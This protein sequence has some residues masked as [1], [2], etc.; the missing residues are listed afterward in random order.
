MNKTLFVVLIPVLL[1]FL[2]CQ[3]KQTQDNRAENQV[4]KIAVLIEYA[5]ST[6]KV[7]RQAFGIRVSRVGMHVVAVSRRKNVEFILK[8]KASEGSF[9]LYSDHAFA[10]RLD[11]VELFNPEGPAINIQAPGHGLIILSPGSE[12]MLKDGSLYAVPP[13]GEQMNACLYSEGNLIFYGSGKLLLKGNYKHALYSRGYLKLAENCD[14]KVS[15]AKKD[16][17]HILGD[18][19]IEGGQLNINAADDGLKSSGNI[20]INKGDIV[21]RAMKRD[22][23]EGLECS[24]LTLN[25][26]QMRVLAYDDAINTAR[27]LI[28]N[29][30]S[31]YCYSLYNDGIDSNGSIQINGGLVVSSGTQMPEEGIDCDRNTFVIT[32]G[33]VIASGGGTSVP[34]ARLSTQPSLIYSG[35]F[36]QSIHIRGVEG[37][38]ILTYSL[39][40]SYYQFTLLYSSPALRPGLNYELFSGGRPEGGTQLYGFYTGSIYKQGVKKADFT[41]STMVTVV[42]E[43]RQGGPMNRGAFPPGRP[44]EVPRDPG[45][46]PFDP[47]ELPQS[48]PAKSQTPGASAMTPGD[49]DFNP[50]P[51][52]GG[53]YYREAV[54]VPD[55]PDKL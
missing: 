46:P 23:S 44:G 25:G 16:G 53:M 47:A 28:I 4:S 8:G 10:L 22:G 43:F 54:E 17:F 14:I 27:N 3:Q 52:Q 33:T 41:T 26:G 38:D 42:G 30:G 29:G 48:S 35:D 49:P 18:I 50:N 37:E 9:K 39:Q 24:Q 2:S 12:N 6:I 11:G 21:V 51:Q 7:S 45:E 31:L 20:L 36:E 55:W 19:L 15:E 34:T 32:G 5:D 13:I 40:R 1:S